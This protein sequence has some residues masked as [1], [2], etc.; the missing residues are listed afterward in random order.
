MAKD[1]ENGFKISMEIM[2]SLIVAGILWV[3][4][5]VTQTQQDVVAIRVNQDNQK[6]SL[7]DLKKFAEDNRKMIRELREK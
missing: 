2:G 4:V 3:G 1:N 7:A 6:E 5:T